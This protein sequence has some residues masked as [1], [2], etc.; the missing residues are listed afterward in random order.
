MK[1]YPD[2]NRLEWDHNDD[3]YNS[4]KKSNLLISDFSGVV[5][6]YAFIFEKPVIY[7]KNVFDP[8]PYDAYWI[9]RPMWL[10]RVTEKIGI[11]LT[12]ENVDK[13]GEIIRKSLHSEDLKASR[14]KAKEESWSHIGKSAVLVVEYL[15]KKQEEL[16][17]EKT[18]EEFFE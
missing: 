9:D 7:A 2:S 4:L 15:I 5:L 18:E 16:N 17:E 3:N 10:L 12:E 6:D 14:E 11:E 8:G 13:I 1:K